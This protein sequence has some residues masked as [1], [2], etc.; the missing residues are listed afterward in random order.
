MTFVI[1]NKISFKQLVIYV[2]KNYLILLNLKNSRTE[3]TNSHKTNKQT[4]KQTKPRKMFD[5]IIFSCLTL[6][7]IATR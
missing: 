1:P 4:N 7:L 2:E 3:S 6:I 5:M